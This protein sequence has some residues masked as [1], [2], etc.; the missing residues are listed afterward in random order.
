MCI[1]PLQFIYVIDHYSFRNIDLKG[2]GEHND[3]TPVAE[4]YLS[5]SWIYESSS[6]LSDLSD[7]YP[8]NTLTTRLMPKRLLDNRIVQ[9]VHKLKE[10]NFHFQCKLSSW[11]STIL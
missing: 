9:E 8:N 7:F 4:E 1:S 2:K 11:H 6:I 5:D 3:S 10:C